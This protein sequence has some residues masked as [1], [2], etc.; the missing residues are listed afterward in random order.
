MPRRMLYS[1]AGNTRIPQF[2]EFPRQVQ[3]PGPA[4]VLRTIAPG[5]ECLQRRLSPGRRAHVRD[6]WKPA[7]EHGGEIANSRPQAWR[8]PR[9]IGVAPI[10]YPLVPCPLFRRVRK[11]ERLTVSVTQGADRALNLGILTPGCRRQRRIDVEHDFRQGMHALDVPDE[12][13]R[14]LRLTFWILRRGQHERQLRNHPV[15]PADFD[16]LQGLIRASA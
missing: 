11:Y 14:S 1:E 13:E 4:V 7:A 5:G 16:G 3:L 10:R 12:L 2:D 15:C 9:R 6:R 8:E